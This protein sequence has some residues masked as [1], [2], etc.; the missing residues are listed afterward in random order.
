M[1]CV[2]TEPLPCVQAA[3]EAAD[4]HARISRAEAKWKVAQ[5]EASEGQSALATLQ[6]DL[7]RLHTAI[8]QALKACPSRCFVSTLHAL[9]ACAPPGT[10]RCLS[11]LAQS[12]FPAC[13][14]TELIRC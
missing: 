7:G 4:L 14:M 3:D 1:L 5:G 2:A 9:A 11:W 10:T 8:A 12:P 13:W 6:A